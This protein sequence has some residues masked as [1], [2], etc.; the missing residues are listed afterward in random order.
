MPLER[1]GCQT[2]HGSAELMTCQFGPA[3]G[4]T[5]ALIGD[6]HA[7]MYMPALHPIA[8]ER[9]WRL[10]PLVKS[11]CPPVIG[12][13]NSTQD[14]IDGGRT[15]RTWRRKAIDWVV[16]NAPERVILAF[17]DNYR[18]TTARGRYIPVADRPE[19]WRDGLRRTLAALPDASRVLVVGDVPTNRSNPVIC[20]RKHRGNLAA[21]VTDRETL[22]ERTIESAIRSATASRG[23][24]FGTIYGKVCTYDPCPLVQGGVLAWRDDGHLTRTIVERLT[25]SVREMVADTLTPASRRGRRG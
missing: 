5:V 2:M 3:D 1:D 21:C 19:A 15:C 4:R 11:A 24:A 16:Q 14:E 7:M 18:I 9:G 17:S 8:V 25:P 23:A 13:H 10:V 6:S 20:L 22:A 12:I